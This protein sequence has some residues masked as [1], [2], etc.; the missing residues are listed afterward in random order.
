MRGEWH[1]DA[2]RS[3][4][5]SL[6]FSL[7]LVVLVS[8]FGLG[9]ALDALFSR[10]SDT[11][12]DYLSVITAI[13]SDMALAMNNVGNLDEFMDSSGY[14]ATVTPVEEFSLPES[15]LT[16]LK[17]GEPVVLESDT[18]L[19]LNYYIPNHLQ[20]LSLEDIPAL[21]SAKPG[22]QI[23]FTSMFYIGTL[24]LVLLWLKPLL[25]RLGLLRK[26][27]MEF[28]SGNLNSRVDSQ[29]ISYIADI[30]KE[31]NRM[32]ERIQNQVD[33][34]KLLTSAVSHDLRTPLA[35]LRFG[36]DTMAVSD[37]PE[38]RAQYLSRVS[39][40]LD[41]M[42]SQIDSLLRFARLDNVMDDVIKEQI[43]LADLAAECVAQ[44]A[45]ES[46]EVTLRAGNLSGTVFGSI[47]HLGTLVNNLLQNAVNHAMTKVEVQVQSRNNSIELIVA[48]DGPGLSLDKVENLLKPFQRGESSKGF[49]LGLA[50]VSRIALHHRAEL[51]PGVAESL[52]G[53]CFTVRFPVS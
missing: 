12:E 15:I 53:A 10:V 19:S 52:G 49:G 36:I 27:S 28:G 25:R 6:T 8:I 32:A 33:D 2:E 14:A 37:Q 22:L 11:D 20:V 31:F 18:G 9:W 46:V 40:D 21:D 44:Y 41:E 1:V 5:R 17:S 42:E 29:G 4:M 7:L 23:L 43:N 24:A 50:V 34:N 16:Q 38:A 47:D 39:S 13:G 35:R 30:E 3:S 45:D 26:A 48:D 51:I